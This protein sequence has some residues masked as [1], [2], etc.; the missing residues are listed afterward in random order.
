MTFAII[1][2]CTTANELKNGLCHRVGTPFNTNMFIE[3]FHRLLKVVYL[4]NKHNRRIDSLLNALLRIA[5]DKAYECLIKLRKVK[6]VIGYV[7]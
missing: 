1:F 3:A 7:K 5:R 2:N 4:D 6:V